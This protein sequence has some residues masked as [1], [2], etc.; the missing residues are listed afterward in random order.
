[1]KVLNLLKIL[2]LT[3]A[4]MAALF[5]AVFVSGLLGNLILA[6]TLTLRESAPRVADIFNGIPWLFFIWRLG[7]WIRKTFTQQDADR[8]G[9][10]GD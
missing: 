4:G 9:W 1:M 8:L 6:G 10:K 2:A 5:V 7:A 3:V